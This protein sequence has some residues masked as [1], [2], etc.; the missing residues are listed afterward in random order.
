MEQVQEMRKKICELNRY[1]RAYYNQHRSL[2]SDAEYDRMFDALEKMEKETGIVYADSPTQNVGYYPEGKLEK[3]R[4]PIPLLSLDKTKLVS[5]LAA[6][7]KKRA[8]LL[9]LK[10]DGLT[11]KL[12]YENGQLI[13]AATRGDGETGENI[14][15]NVPF[16]Q[17]IPITIPYKK[18]LVVSGEAFIRKDDFEYLQE[19]LKNGN[20]E[21]PKNGRNLAAGSVQSSDPKNCEGRCLR[22][23]PFNVLEGL[24]AEWTD[25][26]E[27]RLS[28]LESMGFQA[29][30]YVYLEPESINERTLEHWIAYLQDIADKDNLPI[31][32]MVVIYDSYEYSRSLGRT[33]RAY[34][35]GLA[36]KFEDDAYE[37]VLRKIEWTPS[38]FGELAPVAVFDTLEIDGCDVS[39]ATL[40]NLTF[41]KELE[42]VPGCR[43]MVSKRNMIIPHVEGN[44]SRGHY[45]DTYP[46]VCPCCGNPTRV[47]SRKTDKGRMIETLHCDNPGC[48]SQVLRKFVHFA[49]K[50]AMNIEGL[51]EA[52]LQRFQEQGWLTS[53]QDIYYL[54]QYKDEIIRME[55]FGEKSYER[56]AAAI[57]ES[58]NTDFA[59]YLT[60]MDIPMIGRTKSRVLSQVFQGDLNKFEEAALGNYD[61]SKLE[62][63]GEILNNNIHAWFAD[64]DNRDQWR[65]LQGEMIF[66]KEDLHMAE[67]RDNPFNG[68]VVVATGKLMNFTRNEINNKILELGGI[69]GGSVTKKTNYLIC[70]EKAGSK[71][72]KAQELGIPILSEEQFL[73]MIA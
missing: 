31:D 47:Y 63:F 35:N 10:L 6:F 13:G 64:E 11:V 4:H 53:F 1:R 59:H 23:I 12:T 9:M 3:V 26:R 40:H 43:I 56:L 67:R 71:L 17:D 45:A 18:R 54:Y 42:L 44:L 30:P 37:T 66:H 62:D 55:G 27:I 7:A 34:R 61:F 52:N 20:G 49:A 36:F 65:C 14:L 70:G 22:F 24:E 46:R 58:R 2:V 38:R 32:G 39:R 69:P 72:K 21:R 48:D 73:E 16:I 68:C 60:A 33:E 15:H 5:E 50:K 29:C 28:E 41:I 51:S 8:V 25:S 57:E 19:S